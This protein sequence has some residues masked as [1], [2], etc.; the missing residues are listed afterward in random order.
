MRIPGR[1]WLR[2]ER[3]FLL[4]SSLL[5]SQWRHWGCVTPKII[6]NMKNSFN[7]ADELDGFDDLSEEDQD[8]IKKAWED[9]HVAAED[10]PETAKKADGED[11]EDE[12]K[13]KK[14]GGKKKAVVDSGPG[15]FKF[16]YASSARSKCKSA[17]R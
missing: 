17:L 7:E 15:V 10:V 14:K 11:D 1:S 3:G 16:E 2:F 9:G 12:D 8:R 13:P 6:S 4:L 5:H